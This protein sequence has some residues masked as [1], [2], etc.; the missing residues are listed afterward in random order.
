ML[1]TEEINKK[2]RYLMVHTLVQF[3]PNSNLAIQ[4]AQQA[5]LQVQ[6]VAQIPVLP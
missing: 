3:V 1:R 2:K 6:A 5:K 4:R